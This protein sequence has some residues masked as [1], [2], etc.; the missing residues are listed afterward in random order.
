MEEKSEHTEWQLKMHRQMQAWLCEADDAPQSISL[1]E[2]IQKGKSDNYS[3]TKLE[4]WMG[5]IE[6]KAKKKAKKPQSTL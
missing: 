2:G 3:L 4:N 6:K 5:M 1:W